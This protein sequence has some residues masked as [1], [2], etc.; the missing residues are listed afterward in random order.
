MLLYGP[1][2]KMRRR[3]IASFI[4]SAEAEIYDRMRDAKNISEQAYRDLV[5]EVVDGYVQMGAISRE[6]AGRIA[7]SFKE[8]YQEMRQMAR[9]SARAAERE[10]EDER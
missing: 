7:E 10:L 1:R 9:E 6:K 5:D 3:K 2:G 4:E 8:R